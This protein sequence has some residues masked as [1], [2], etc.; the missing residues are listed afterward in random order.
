MKDQGLAKGAEGLGSPSVKLRSLANSHRQGVQTL[1]S[2]EWKASDW[3]EAR[4]QWAGKLW[5]GDVASLWAYRRG[6]DRGRLQTKG[7]GL[8]FSIRRE[9]KSQNTF[10]KRL[11][12][13]RFWVRRERKKKRME[14]SENF[15]LPT[16]RGWWP[17][18]TSGPQALREGVRGGQ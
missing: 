17:V 9:N 1:F 2:A 14:L 11:M 6:R 4:L 8:G 7:L 3:P 12:G 18:P 13:L 10:Q 5:E 15:S 16:G